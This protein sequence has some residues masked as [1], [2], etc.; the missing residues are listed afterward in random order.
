MSRGIKV[1]AERKIYAESMGRCMNPECAKYLFTEY[2]DIMEKAHII[3]YADTKDNSYE[4]LIILCPNCH[5]NFDKNNAFS[6]EQVKQWKRIR[7]QELNNYFSI[8]YNSFGELEN[9]IVPLL[10]EN[11]AFF[12]N[13]YIGDNR[14]LWDRFE[15]KILSNNSI[16]RGILKSNLHLIQNNR[17]ESY[18]NLAIVQNYLLHIDEFE[19]TRE[20]EEKKRKVLFPDEINSLFGISP[21]NDFMIPSVESVE[22]LMKALRNKG[23]FKDIVLGVEDPHLVINKCENVERIYLKDTPRLRQFYYENKCFRSVGV[24]LESLNYALKIIRSRDLMFEF[25]N[26]FNLKE[27]VI[28]DVNIVFVYKYCLSKVD[29]LKLAPI[30]ESV[31]VNLHNWNGE[32]CISSEAYQFAGTLGV[33]LLTMERFYGYI[34]NI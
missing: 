17:E 26:T 33:T 8:K 12:V 16:I 27:I 9:V 21:M 19:T 14:E 15:G 29:L 30:K 5:T 24:R 10:A 1:N 18:S 13:Y 32:S 34:N 20:M 22:C 2:G 11:Q 23:Q 4:N 7:E 6:T 3:P 28:N 25:K 31:I